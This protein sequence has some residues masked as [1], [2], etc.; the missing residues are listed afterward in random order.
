M[1]GTPIANM[2]LQDPAVASMIG[3]QSYHGYGGNSFPVPSYGVP[4]LW[5]S[6]TSDLIGSNSTINNGIYWAQKMYQYLT[7]GEVTAW[8]WWWLIGSG[9]QYIAA[10]SGAEPVR[11]YTFAQYSRFV[12]P[13]YY[14][15]GST[16]SSWLINASAYK[17][18]ASGN[19]ALVAINWTGVPQPVTF[20]LSSFP[21]VGSVT[22]WV[23]SASLS[24]AAQ[25]SVNVTGGSFAYT[26]PA[27]SVVTFVG[28]ATP[29]DLY[30]A[31]VVTVAKSG[32]AY[33]FTT[34]RYS[35]SVSIT[36]VTANDIP[37]PVGYVFDNLS[38]NATVY[39]ATGVTARKFLRAAST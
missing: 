9:G 14:R 11:F 22:P 38:S 30:K 5:E 33:N 24:L 21:N 13:G 35:Q 34:R 36:N 19:L 18:P 8:H 39:N 17:D 31:G 3:V 25:S 7:V 6:E 37:G 16:T 4:H 23:T 20:N 2:A 26:M 1:W 29:A 15:I 10:T 12:R 28:Q 27:S 32:F